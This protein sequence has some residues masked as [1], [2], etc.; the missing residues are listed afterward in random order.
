ME[1]QLL[2]DPSLP[3]APPSVCLGLGWWMQ[4]PT[5]WPPLEKSRQSVALD[6]SDVGFLGK[7]WGL[8]G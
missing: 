8:W 2:E 1:L 5:P 6:A 4:T 3:S 7:C